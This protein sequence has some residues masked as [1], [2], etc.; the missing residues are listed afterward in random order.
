LLA[1]TSIPEGPQAERAR[2]EV[3]RTD[4]G[5]GRL[6]VKNTG[7][8]LA[9]QAVSLLAGLGTSVLLARY[10]GV[11]G[12]GEFNYLFAFF[13]FFLALNDF[14]VTTILV[15]E[16]AQQPQRAEELIGAMFTFR[17]LLA[18]ASVAGAWGTIGL[19]GYPWQLRNAL[20]VFAL[21]LPANALQ[22]PAVMFQVLLKA[23]YL[24]AAT[25]L[26]RVGGLALVAATV[27]LGRGLA[28]IAASLVVAE[29]LAALVQ[30]RWASRYV[31]V[32]FRVHPAV[33][34]E[35][36]RS[37][38]PY[39]LAVLAVSLMNR[40]DLL[41]LERLAPLEEMGRYAAA[42]KVT[43]LLETLPLIAMATL[44]PVMARYAT[45]D[46]A[47]LRA[48]HRR[49]VCSFGLVALPLLAVTALGSSWLI[50]LLFGRSFLGAE[51]S[52]VVLLWHTAFLYLALPSGNLLVSLGKERV[53]LVVNLIGLALNAA[54]NIALIPSLGAVGAALAS[55]ATYFFI[56]VAVSAAAHGVLV[57][58]APTP[59]ATA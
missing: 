24:A 46:R 45:E 36:L 23:E 3:P 54:L 44:Y 18:V 15:R 39:G 33:W 8:Q 11:K 32:A 1:Q 58:A 10:L 31:R 25:V 56:W 16:V 2:T 4:G 29:L 35:V 43:S 30:L 20:V 26:S 14:G 19:L 49:A 5:L 41:L 28:A 21:I 37:S 55:S 34:R 42:S 48:L 22:L 6:L 12:F 53:N 17:M 27:W 59:T 52:L 7:V 40:L 13:Y 51:S 50:V 47:R 57:L 38:V 9:A